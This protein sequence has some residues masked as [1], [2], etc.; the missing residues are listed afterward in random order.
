MGGNVL[1]WHRRTV[2]S[3]WRYVLFLCECMYVCVYI[4]VYMCVCVSCMIGALVHC[5]LCMYLYVTYVYIMC[6][7]C[8]CVFPIANGMY[9]HVYT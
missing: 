3:D 4:C 2:E 5:L 6:A 1:G 8:M 9:M 7:L